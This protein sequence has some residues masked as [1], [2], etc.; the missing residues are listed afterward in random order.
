MKKN[1]HKRNKALLKKGAKL[2]IKLKSHK[3]LTY[4]PPK[5]KID[6]IYLKGL[7][8]LDK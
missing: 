6:E 5:G 2:L 4:K 7:K 8:D 3:S 1:N